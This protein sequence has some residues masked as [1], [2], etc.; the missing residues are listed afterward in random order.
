MR[1]EKKI[2]LRLDTGLI[3]R[4]QGRADQERIPLS[5]LLRHL[6][7]RF[8]EEKQTTLPAFLVAT[9]NRTISE[10]RADQLQE[11]F[12]KEVCSLFD[13]FRKQGLEVKEAAKRT[14][15]ALKAKNHPWATY[16]V[17]AGV[18]RDARRFRTKRP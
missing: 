14:N 11:E 9:G 12:A 5:Y 7:I 3:D 4:L 6:V 16:E 8:L 17:V 18:L 15:F 2:S 10:G 1:L 13:G